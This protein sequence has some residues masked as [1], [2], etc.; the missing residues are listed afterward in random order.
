[1]I[2][3]RSANL[4]RGAE[5]FTQNC[6]GCHGGTGQGDGIASPVL[7]PRPANLAVTQFSTELLSDVTP[8][9]IPGTAM[10]SWRDRGD[11]LERARNLRAILSSRTRP[12]VPARKIWRAENYCSNKFVPHV[13]ARSEMERAPP[14][15]ASTAAHQPN[16]RTA[17]SGLYNAGDTRWC[18]RHRD[19]SNAKP[20]FR[21]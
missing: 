9:G 11:R 12:D 3:K 17:G 1:M 18:S 5:L 14:P 6:A 13:T 4:K 7:L 10:P 16:T 19:A 2:L 21:I 15:P 20:A 8:D